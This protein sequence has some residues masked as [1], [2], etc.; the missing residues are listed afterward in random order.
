M[1]FDPTPFEMLPA[2]MHWALAFGS[3]LMI[4][5]AVAFLSS[6]AASGISGPIAVMGRVRDV[7]VDTIR[8]SP[9]RTWA[10]TS[11][12]IKEAI[13]R[14]ALMVFVIFAILFMFAGWFLSDS[15]MRPDAQ[16]KVYVSFVLTAITWLVLPVVL[17]LS[18]W[19]L[20]DDIKAR[21]LHTVVTKPARKN[22][23]V[24]GRM[25][26]FSVVGTLVL[27]IM[28]GVGYI[29]IQRQVPADAA[30]TCRVPVYGTIAFLDREGRPG[31]GVNVGDVWEF[32]SY[33]EG[34]TK[35]A[36]VWDFQIDNTDAESLVLESQFEA[37]RT[38]K[39][40]VGK[41][42]TGLLTFINDIRTQSANALETN[43]EMQTLASLVRQG[44]F[45]NAAGELD[46][47]SEQFAQKTLSPTEYGFS[48]IS[49]G[50][51]QF[52]GVTAPLQSQ[53]PQLSWLKELNQTSLQCA[54]AASAGDHASMG[55]VLK[56]LS[57]I[58]ADNADEMKQ[59]IVNLRPQGKTFQIH[60]FQRN[61]QTVSRK[62]TY[63]DNE[64]K[65]MQTVDL[66]DDLT[67]DGKLRV[68]VQ[69]L[70]SGQFLGMARPDLF[71]R[72]PDRPFYQGYA[73][74]ILGI[75]LMLVLIVVLSV[76]ASSFVKGPVAVMLTFT[77]IVVG[78][79][80]REFMAK[81]V[82]G[83]QQGG[84]PCESWYRLV[85]HM[86]D[87][88]EL[89]DSLLTTSMQSVDGVLINA[90]WLIQ[91]IVPNFS[92]YQMSPYVANGFDVPWSASLLPS[93]VITVAYLLPC[94]LI[95]YYSLSL[96]ELESK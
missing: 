60:E 84:G 75:W 71:I 35:A 27:A 68:E 42:L 67:Y 39:G 90:L 83:E 12:T 46:S 2:L 6:F 16:V 89:P 1:S 77:L 58:F 65:S 14:K 3:F 53:R 52:A 34:A 63:Y 56:K 23:I 28:A 88:S 80:F 29:W 78:Q 26:G 43:L 41:G 66:F 74:A 31:K 79:G 38:H 72:L 69:C 10:L 33:V 49:L 15:E 11:L 82:S 20:P 91:N 92:Y 4:I 5:F 76:T 47:L 93:I 8:L 25:L 70:D 9:R 64:S 13:R 32:R 30:L 21:S 7:I 17:L 94:L 50:F 19:G 87:T 57:T 18:C 73:K 86:N 45:N 61:V 44:D 62:I 36:A 81:L 55:G 51:Q 95:G 85:F 59:L 24:L 48:Q 40:D 54:Q 37:F 22:E 96:R